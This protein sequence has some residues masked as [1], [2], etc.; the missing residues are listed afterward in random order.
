MYV[1]LKSERFDSFFLP[2][3]ALVTDLYCCADK[4]NKNLSFYQNKFKKELINFFL[5]TTV[6]LALNLKTISTII[7]MISCKLVKSISGLSEDAR[8]LVYDFQM[9]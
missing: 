2:H 9:M 3:K 8:A 5:S 1:I 7:L 6:C 4:N